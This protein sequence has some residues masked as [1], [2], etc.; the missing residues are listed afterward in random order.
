MLTT[1]GAR[2]SVTLLKDRPGLNPPTLNAM[3]TCAMG[4]QRISMS[5]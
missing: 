4:A 2:L 1:I 5:P 3:M